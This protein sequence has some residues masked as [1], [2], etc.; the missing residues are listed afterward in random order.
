M[1]QRTK[2]EWEELVREYRSSGKSLRGWCDEKG[3]NYKTM[4]GN[5]HLVPTNNAKRSEKE[6]IDLIREQR[7]SGMGRE[8]WCRERSVNP[9]SMYSAEKRLKEKLSPNSVAATSKHLSVNAIASVPTNTQKEE[10]IEESNQVSTGTTLRT[11]LNKPHWIEVGIDEPLESEL[12]SKPRGLSA[13][14]VV[15]S[16]ET[17]ALRE[18]EV[19]SVGNDYE[20]GTQKDNSFASKIMIRCGKLTIEADAS[21]PPEHLGNLIGKLA[22]VC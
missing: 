13:S 19:F 6:W 10:P 21:Y 17:E 9:N 4:C 22:L 2:A 7:A 1:K 14:P 16:P 8:G 18:S 20:E 5:T 12:P 3:V 11:T 15:S